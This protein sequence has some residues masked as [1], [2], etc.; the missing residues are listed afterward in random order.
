MYFI[1]NNI[2]I[3]QVVEFFSTINLRYTSRTLFNSFVFGLSLWVAGV[4]FSINCL[5][6]E[7]SAK[8]AILVDDVTG[9][10]LF[11]KNEDDLMYPASMSKLMTLYIVFELI[12]KGKLSLDDKFLVSEKAWR[13]GGSRMFLEV[14]SR[15]LISD[16]LRGIIVQS[17]NDACIVL[18]EGIA[19]SEEAFADLMNIRSKSIGLKSS[20][21]VNSTGWPHKN[22]LTTA[23]DLAILVHR[24]I[25]D[26]P[27]FY[28]IFSE[29]E[30]KYN[31]INQKNRN[32]LLRVYPGADGLKTGYTKDSG[33]GLAASAKRAERRLIIVANGIKS[34]KQRAK[35]TGLLLDYGFSQFNNH[36]LFTKGE[37]VEELDVWLGKEPKVSLII[38]SNLTLTLSR[39]ARKSM[40][41][42]VIAPGPIP[43]PIEK[44][45]AIAQLKVDLPDRET[46]RIPLVAGKSIDSLSGFGRI[47]KA[48]NHLIWGENK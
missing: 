8:Q 18:A 32:P 35:E 47:G 6:F 22:H 24:I 25:H 15:V 31:N 26:F 30:F 11:S 14:G 17:G 48:F 45:Q 28:A 27:K 39:E 41:V 40:R 33:Y 46:I 12:D 38:E 36:V 42:S 13:M 4:I 23:K 2:L 19:G 16:L 5:A 29:R 7:T 21:F 3:T 10:V 34:S 43:A 37:I 44:G 20:N 1:K 9:T